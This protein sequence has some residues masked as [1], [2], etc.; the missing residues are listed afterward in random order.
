M[1]LERNTAAYN[2]F[3]ISLLLVI[4]IGLLV[5]AVNLY[6]GLALTEIVLILLPAAVFVRRT[7]Q[8]LSWM[9]PGTRAT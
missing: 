7:R 1:R 5:Q 2:L 4:A 6:F 9:C 3:A 8:P